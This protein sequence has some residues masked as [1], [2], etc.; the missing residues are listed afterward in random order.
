MRATAS[1]DLDPSDRSG[2]DAAPVDPAPEWIV[3]RESIQQDERPA[4]SAASDPAQVY[5]LCRR[6]ADI[7][8]GS[9]KQAEGGNATQDVVGGRARGIVDLAGGEKGDLTGNLA[10]GQIGA[11]GRNN[12]ILQLVGLSG[13]RCLRVDPADL[14]QQN[15]EEPTQLYSQPA[16]V[17]ITLSRP[18]EAPSRT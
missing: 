6:M 16:T 12:E 10:P 3:Q 7:T 13:I 4:G 18:K 8:A 15:E 5:T 9:S 17:H 1:E 11:C 2:A 14:K